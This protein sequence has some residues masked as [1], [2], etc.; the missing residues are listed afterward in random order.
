ML[1]GLRRAAVR[2]RALCCLRGWQGSGGGGGGAGS[3]R[4]RR[5]GEWRGAEP[6]AAAAR[7]PRSRKP[8]GQG[9]KEGPAAKSLS[10]RSSW[11]L[12]EPAPPL[13]LQTPPTHP[14]QP[15]PLTGGG[16]GG[17]GGLRGAAMPLPR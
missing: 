17:S 6:G 12:G 10:N 14:P 13:R 8:R 2:L 1:C 16:G 5:R 3:E 11:I 15:R 7:G 4:R 9:R